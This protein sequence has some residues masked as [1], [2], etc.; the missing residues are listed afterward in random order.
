MVQVQ[1][2]PRLSQGQQHQC[3]VLQ[4]ALQSAELGCLVAAGVGGGV[5]DVK[6]AD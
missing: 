3:S 1:V 5:V 2:G 6:T 4:T